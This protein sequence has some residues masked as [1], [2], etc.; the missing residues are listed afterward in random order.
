[1]QTFNAAHGRVLAAPRLT[2]GLMTPLARQPGA[3][4][5]LDLEC[6]LARRADEL[7]FAALWTRDVPLSIPQ[8]S[9]QEAAVLDDPFLWLGMLASVTRQTALGT[10]AAV[11]PLRDPLH[12]AK[13]ALSLDR[14]T[15]GR[16]VLGLGSGDRA[17]EFAA[18]GVDLEA[19]AALFRERWDV[20]R[21]ALSLH[22]AQRAP[23][24]AATGGYEVLAPAAAI[25]PMLVVGSA[26]QSLQWI[27]TH[28]QG[29]ATYHREETRQ[30][31]RIG[32]W[33][34][35]VAERAQGRQRAFIQSLGLDLLDDPLAP[36]EPIELGMRGGRIA[37]VAYLQRLEAAG[38][39]HVLLHPTRGRRP[40]QDVIEEL[41]SKVLPV[42]G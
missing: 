33:R 17:A 28:A 10:A 38:V 42:F 1:M 6:A 21:A 2:I 18:F 7:G 25:V 4:P 40:V 41:G 13:S 20:V 37:L 15:G 22:A 8:G 23:L 27:A 32:L 16:L 3:P 26:R 29:W 34:T 9:D 24:L 31:G 36:A 39:A 30:Q 12:L 5:D 19:R 14:M 35:A 11:L